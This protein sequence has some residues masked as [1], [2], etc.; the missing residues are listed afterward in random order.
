MAGRTVIDGGEMALKY[1]LVGLGVPLLVISFFCCCL[2]RLT[3]S[4]CPNLGDPKFQAA[5][6]QGVAL[7]DALEAYNTEHS[8]Y[9]R[10]LKELAPRYIAEIPKPDWGDGWKYFVDAAGKPILDLQCAGG[11]ASILYKNG[12]WQYSDDW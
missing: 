2:P 5:Q 7:V 12:E 10:T 8:A 4:D 3:G 6:D 9:P 11:D 1:I